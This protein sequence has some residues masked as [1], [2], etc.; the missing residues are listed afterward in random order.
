MRYI[1]DYLKF[2]VIAAAFAVLVGYVLLVVNDPAKSQQTQTSEPLAYGVVVQTTAANQIISTNPTRRFIE[3]CNMS[4]A[5]TVFIAP[6]PM[7]ATTSNQAGVTSGGSLSLFPF[8]A[9]ATNPLPFCYRTPFPF[10][11]Q[12]GGFVGAAWNAIAATTSGTQST[13]LG[14]LTIF[15][16]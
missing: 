5:T 16:Y 9:T 10:S 11:Q 7:V 6:L 8:T 3:I 12:S 2:P 14:A 1:R 13:P 15:E 4:Q